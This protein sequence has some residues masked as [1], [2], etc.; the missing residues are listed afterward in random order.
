MLASQVAPGCNSGP[1]PAGRDPRS[2][3][4][5]EGATIAIYGG[6]GTVSLEWICDVC[7]RATGPS[8]RVMS[9]AKVVS[10]WLPTLSKMIPCVHGKQKDI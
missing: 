5:N 3:R 4:W 2:I 1:Q 6:N 9:D 10:T 7:A 8:S